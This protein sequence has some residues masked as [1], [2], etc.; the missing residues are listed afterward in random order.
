MPTLQTNA[1]NLSNLLQIDIRKNL[2]DFGF[3]NPSR[4]F[5]EIPNQIAYMHGYKTNYHVDVQID[6][7]TF[8]VL[9]VHQI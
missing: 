4:N 1:S 8:F 5:F 9:Q 6:L 3:N 7:C 2:K